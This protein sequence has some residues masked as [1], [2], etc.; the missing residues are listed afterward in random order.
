VLDEL[1]KRLEEDFKE[2]EE[3]KKDSDQNLFR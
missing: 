3:E 2:E 1:T